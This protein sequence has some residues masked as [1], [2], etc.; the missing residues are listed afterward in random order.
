MKMIHANVAGSY[1]NLV[2]IFGIA[3]AAFFLGEL[4]SLQQ[5]VG[6]AITLSAVTWLSLVGLK[7]VK[8]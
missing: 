8:A 5:L 3:G 4:T 1:R 2:P 7:P 6:A